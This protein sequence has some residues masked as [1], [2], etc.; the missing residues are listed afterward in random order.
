M[1]IK[2]YTEEDFESMLV[3]E[4]RTIARAMGIKKMAKARRDVAIAAILERQ[5]AVEQTLTALEAIPDSEDYEVEDVEIF[6]E[7]YE[8]EE[9]EVDWSKSGLPMQSIKARVSAEVTNPLAKAG[10]KTTSTIRV[11]AGASYGNYEVVGKTVGDVMRMLS[12]VLNIDSGASPLV[13]GDQVSMDY[14]LKDD[15]SLEFLKPAGDK[16]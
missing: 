16:G 13:N 8:E 1:Q 14:V 5:E 6:E 9:Q 3:P 12:E 15:D 4:I 10:M 7:E 2:K 11:S